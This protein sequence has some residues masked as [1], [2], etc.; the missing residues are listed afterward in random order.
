M[1]HLLGELVARV[2]IKIERVDH[3]LGEL[4]LHC[5]ERIIV[6]GDCAL[7]PGLLGERDNRAHHRTRIRQE[8]IAE[9]QWVQLQS[10]TRELWATHR[11]DPGLQIGGVE[12]HC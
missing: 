5:D 2:A 6:G 1:E 3:G 9:P 4:L 12:G 7:R 8:G 10:N 11:L